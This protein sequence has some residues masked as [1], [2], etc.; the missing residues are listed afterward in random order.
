MD[1]VDVIDRYCAVWSDPDS[2]RRAAL[3]AQV[4]AEGATYT[5]PTAHLV[6]AAG[7][8][9]HI[10][11]IMTKRPGGKVLRTSE[12]DVH[13]GAVR[14]AWKAVD[15]DGATL[16]DGI[17]LVLLS[18]DERKIERIVGFFGELEPLGAA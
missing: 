16:R 15:A 1:V 8:L 14:F 3:L 4:W 5:D 11:R 9:A 12:L 10:E 13:H 2:S 7:L 6:G 17:D 18:K